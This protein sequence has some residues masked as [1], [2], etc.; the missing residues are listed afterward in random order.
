MLVRT[1]RPISGVGRTSTLI[2]PPD[3]S[4][5]E[6]ASDKASRTS[7]ESSVLEVSAHRGHRET[8]YAYFTVASRSIQA[9]RPTGMP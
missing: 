7:D 9:S 8:V 6:P 3:F 1:C 4:V 5:S 2:S